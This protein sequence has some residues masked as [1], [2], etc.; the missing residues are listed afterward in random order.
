[1]FVL[2]V[3]CLSL[4]EKTGYDKNPII[5]Q[6]ATFSVNT[7]SDLKVKHEIFTSI[8]NHE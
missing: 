1:L 4:L 2:G 8:N 3:E 7:N 5:N 6:N